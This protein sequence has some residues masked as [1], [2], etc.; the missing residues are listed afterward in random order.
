MWEVLFNPIYG[1]SI[2]FEWL[3]TEEEEVVIF[4]VFLLRIM[5]LKRV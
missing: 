1:I 4:D 3:T 5:F 2:G